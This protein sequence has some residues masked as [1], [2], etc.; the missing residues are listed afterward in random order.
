MA[1]A[2]RNAFRNILKGFRRGSKTVKGIESVVHEINV[3]RSSLGKDFFKGFKVTKDAKGEF[4]IGQESL[5]S[6][7]KIL[8][9]GNLRRLMRAA[10]AA[11]IKVK[12]LP[13]DAR[14]FQEA[15]NG[16]KKPAAALE[17]IT[18]RISTKAARLGRAVPS[19]AKANSVKGLSKNGAQA[20]K[21]FNINLSNALKGITIGVVVLATSGAIYAGTDYLVRALKRKK[22]CF[23]HTF[24]PKAKKVISCKVGTLSCYYEFGKD[25]CFERANPG[26]KEMDNQLRTIVRSHLYNVTVVLM[27]LV[28][29]PTNPLTK[30]I[31]DAVNKKRI[32]EK[33]SEFTNIN[34]S[35]MEIR[36]KYFDIVEDLLQESN[37]VEDRQTLIWNTTICDLKHD[38]L[39]EVEDEKPVCRMCSP[40]ADPKSTMYVDP[41]SYSDDYAFSC[42]SDPTIAEVMVETAEDVGARILDKI[43]RTIWSVLKPF[44][45]AAGVILA[46]VVAIILIFKYGGSSS[47]AKREEYEPL[48]ED[49]SYDDTFDD[50]DEETFTEEMDAE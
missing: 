11:G 28:K 9:S 24:D 4:K 38:G 16:L 48:I 23:I 19:L 8:K 30:V 5:H 3:P 33:A 31:L 50:A 26:G 27:A 40:S 25:M 15:A 45:I 21:Q 46:L 42:R 1:S 43:G 7:Q 29:V 2:F 17:K 32:E 47:T 44:M 6:F 13:G 35:L 36:E 18:E 37:Y 20:V 34:D 49:D 41:E 22:G 14:A 12:T 39:K 10:K